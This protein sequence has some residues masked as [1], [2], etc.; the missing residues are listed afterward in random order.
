MAERDAKERF[1]VGKN[2]WRLC[3]SDIRVWISGP[4]GKQLSH[5]CRMCTIG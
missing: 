4:N 3:D 1:I 2:P 5:D